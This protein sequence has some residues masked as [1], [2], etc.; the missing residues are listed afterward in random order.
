MKIIVQKC[1]TSYECNEMT[2]NIEVINGVN[3]K[4]QTRQYYVK[5]CNIDHCK[6]K[7]YL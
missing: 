7:M 2:K 3:I 1:C 4:S 6:N 5:Q